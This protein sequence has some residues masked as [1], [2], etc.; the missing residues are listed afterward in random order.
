MSSI[1]ATPGPP[2]RPQPDRDPYFYGWRDVVIRDE[3][4]RRVVRQPL[5]RED[6]LHPHE[7]DC[8]PQ[9]RDHDRDV[10]YLR[11]VLVTQL[12]GEPTTL[13]AHD[14]L[15][16][17]GVP[18]LKNHSPDLV[19]IPDAP[20]PHPRDSFDVA[21]A[22]VRPQLIVEVTSPSTHDLDLNDKRRQYWQAGVP[23]Y[24]IVEEQFRRG[25]RHLRILPYRRGPR[26]YRRQRLASTAGSGWRRSTCGWD[27]R[28]AGSSST[29]PR[30]NGCLVTANSTTPWSRLSNRP[31][32]PTSALRMRSSERPRPSNR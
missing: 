4:G 1:R 30:E 29:T 12:Q 15:I 23:V 32:R 2:D 11:D 7:G 6:A 16:L 14:L 21:A 5:T 25:R 28:M 17:W 10:T 8:M 13:V 27:R 20:L 22:G 24:V 26:A 9:N 19:V 31:S 18:G 3:K